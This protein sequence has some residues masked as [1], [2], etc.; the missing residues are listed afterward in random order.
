MK[1]IYAAESLFRHQ[2][3]ILSCANF[4]RR[5]R[6]LANTADAS[7]RRAYGASKRGEMMPG[8]GLKAYTY[9]ARRQRERT[10]P[11]FRPLRQRQQVP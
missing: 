2:S 10:E 3:P 7:S 1:R 6:R 11:Y 9:D 8:Q 5:G 4:A